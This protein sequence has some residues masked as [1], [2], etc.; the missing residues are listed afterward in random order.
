MFASYVLTGEAV[1]SQSNI[2]LC[3]IAQT[4]P[5]LIRHNNYL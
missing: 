2:L 1:A 4:H 3:I 5:N